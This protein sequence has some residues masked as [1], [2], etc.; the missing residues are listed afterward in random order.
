M[1]IYFNPGNA[2][3]R[4]ARNSMIYVDKTELLDYLNRVLSTENKCI[5][6]S[7]ARRFGKSHAAGMIDAYYSLGCDSTELFGDTKIAD[8]TKHNNYKKYMNKYNVIH[9]DIS[10]FW[11]NYKDNLL[12][13]ITEYIYKDFKHDFGNELDYDD[14]LNYNLIR[15]YKK[16]NIQ[17]VIII[18]EW[19]CVIRNS[20]DSKLV[21]SY[22]QFLHSLFKS[23]ES[24]AYLA[25]AYITGILPIKKIKDES[26]LNNFSEYTMVKSKPI[27]QYYGFT[28]DEV[29]VL[30]KKFDMDFESTKAWY[31]G[32]LID[33]I[34]MYNPNSVSM[35]MLRNDFDSY[36]KNTSSFASINTFITMNYAGLKDDVL[37]ML[38]GGKVKVNTN[39]FQN[40]LSIITSRDDALT[41]LIHLGY[42][43]YDAER[44][45]SY[46]PNYE[47]ATTFESALQTGEWK[48]IA[49]TIS[50]CDELLYETIDGNAERVA[51]L[52][53]LA[54]DAY[55]SVLKYNDE[56]SLSCVLTMAYFTAPGYYNIIRE[57]PAGK[58]FAD[59][60]FIPRANA[61][62]RPAMVIELKYN[63]SADT[64][65]K[66][67][68][69]K[70]YH[71]ALSGYSEKI[72]LVGI[73]YD[74]NGAGDK[75][76]SCVIEE[77]KV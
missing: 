8:E 13:K 38:A 66:Q 39:T 16:T 68:K 10:S 48:E 35:A 21:H 74:A 59:F 75:H 34:H 65:I 12:E 56:N 53:E 49:K 47:V 44:K 6:V 60:A 57:M 63:K 25:L 55:T 52:I 18:D 11:D 1:G 45:E 29:K 27:T 30:C 76:H 28:E 4:Q 54:H 72:L 5:A 36:W 46:V 3:F 62:F 31:N 15:I 20:N 41:A 70:R 9:L 50:C 69:E 19:D 26:A 37:T 7:H 14:S 51:E 73:S 43:G 40:D 33:G 2:S 77:V 23:E 24:K 32:Y 58:G 64:A 67:I 42:L 17:F 61:G 71:G 22:L